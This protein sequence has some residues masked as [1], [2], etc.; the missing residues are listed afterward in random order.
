MK[1]KIKLT[2]KEISACKML[3]VIGEQCLKDI[4]LYKK[5]LKR[6]KRKNG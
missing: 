5:Y 6:G 4:G 1:D 2:K 3:G